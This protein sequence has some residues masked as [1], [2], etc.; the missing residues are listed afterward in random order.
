MQSHEINRV[1]WHSRRGMLELDLLLVPFV[2]DGGYEALTVAQRETYCQMIE[3]EDPVLF[4]WFL[5][6]GDADQPFIAMVKWV[7]DWHAQTR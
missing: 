4:D 7:K 3:Q 6:K 1:F 5:G 2:K